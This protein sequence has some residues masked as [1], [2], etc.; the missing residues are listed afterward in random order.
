M[1]LGK[2]LA[3]NIFLTLVVQLFSGFIFDPGQVPYLGRKLS[4][5]TYYPG[6]MSLCMNVSQPST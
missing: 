1:T 5:I 6:E 3:L 4:T 2:L